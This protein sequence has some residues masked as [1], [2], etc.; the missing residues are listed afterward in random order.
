MFHWCDTPEG[1]PSAF[2]AE[3][4]GLVSMVSGDSPPRKL[5][6]WQEMAAIIVRN[7]KCVYYVCTCV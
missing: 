3:S 1:V 7:I 6:K 2:T 4:E 5:N